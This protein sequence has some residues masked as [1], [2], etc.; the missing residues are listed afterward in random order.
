MPESAVILTQNTP[1]QAKSFNRGSALDGAAVK[2]THRHQKRNIV[3][4]FVRRARL[5]LR[6]A[7]SQ[8]DLA[9]RLAGLGVVITQTG[10]SK[11]ENQERYVMDYEAEA[12]AKALKVSIAW[13]YGCESAA[14]DQPAAKC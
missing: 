6:P 8:D 4:P 11:I 5:R 1:D 13:L 12:L 9:G 2:K 14:G 7:V 3:G 10:I